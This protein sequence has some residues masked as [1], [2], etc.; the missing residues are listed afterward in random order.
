MPDNN[1]DP[2]LWRRFPTS[3]RFENCEM[4]RELWAAV[5]RLGVGASQEPD[6]TIRFKA[7]NWGAINTE[8]HKLRDKRFGEWYFMNLSPEAMFARMI[9]CLRAHSLPYE[10]EFHG[11]RLVLLVPKRD[12]RKHLEVMLE[13]S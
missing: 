11:S 3:F 13:P 8:A 9:G 2:E 7:E 10:L 12:E 6:G 4:Q 5:E 1:I